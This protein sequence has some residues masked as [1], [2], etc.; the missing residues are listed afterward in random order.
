[1]HLRYDNADQRLTPVG[2]AYGLVQDD[3]WA[4]FLRMKDRLVR[5]ADALERLRYDGRPIREW[6]KRPEEEGERFLRSFD[7]LRE[8]ADGSDV[9]TRALIAVKYEGYID[10][11]QRLIARF[12]E[13]ED[14]P[15]PA[16]ID[17]RALKQ[18]RREAVERWSAVRPRN[19]GQAARVSGVH[20]TDVAMLLVHIVGG[21]K[22]DRTEVFPPE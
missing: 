13:L 5:L 6:L 18:F 14:Q 2:R 17:Y 4:H 19:V 8:L 16:T 1:M 3:R 12:R 9:W 22:R 21:R 15:I 10:R 11:Q 20:P 7:E